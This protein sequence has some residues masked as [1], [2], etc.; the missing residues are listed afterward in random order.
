MAAGSPPSLS[1]TPVNVSYCL[2]NVQI[3][4]L[5]GNHL[6]AFGYTHTSN[7]LFDLTLTAKRFTD[8]LVF[9]TEQNVIR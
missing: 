1:I 8:S 7:K 4:Q 5:Q 9:L 3:K 6:P 2:P